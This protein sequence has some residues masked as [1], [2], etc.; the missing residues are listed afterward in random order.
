MY[1]A[2]CTT[3]S[4][5]A[6]TLSMPCENPYNRWVSCDKSSYLGL[7]IYCALASRIVFLSYLFL[8]A[9]IVVAMTLLVAFAVVVVILVSTHICST[10][11][12]HCLGLLS[13]VTTN[14][15]T[16]PPKPLSISSF[17]LQLSVR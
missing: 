12:L 3:S 16:F 10:Y 17:M 15:H 2:Q 13:R 7:F 6:Q 4:V 8:C 9:I 5:S 14:S 1:F 11:P